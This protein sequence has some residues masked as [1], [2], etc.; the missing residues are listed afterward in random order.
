MSGQSLKSGVRWVVFG[1][2]AGVMWLCAG[3]ARGA[4]PAVGVVVEAAT[5][6]ALNE[7]A[8]LSKEVK[9]A[10]EAV[11]KANDDPDTDKD[12]ISW[13][14]YYTLGPEFQIN[15]SIDLKNEEAASYAKIDYRVPLRGTWDSWLLGEREGKFLN[16]TYYAKT[17]EPPPGHHN[18]QFAF[19]DWAIAMDGHVLFGPKVEVG[20]DPQADPKNTTSKTARISTSNSLPRAVGSLGLQTTLK[21]TPDGSGKNA[22]VSVGYWDVGMANA[23]VRVGLWDDATPGAEP[24]GTTEM[25]GEYVKL[26]DVRFVKAGDS[27][28][29]PLYDAEGNRYT[30][31][32]VY[33]TAAAKLLRFDVG[34]TE[35]TWGVNYAMANVT[36]SSADLIAIGNFNLR[37]ISSTWET[38]RT[39]YCPNW[40]YWLPRIEGGGATYE[41]AWAEMEAE[42]EAEGITLRD[43][44]FRSISESYQVSETPGIPE[45]VA[46][47]TLACAVWGCARRRA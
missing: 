20:V 47:L 23:G 11:G 22:I 43:G 12:T 45:P 15:L 29:A 2:L 41:Q 32:Q 6:V 38:D 44:L 30:N 19:I 27:V 8:Q 37:S 40:N 34:A 26:Y 35:G 25:P 9:F 18:P 5:G 7:L 3:G 1:S 39:F 42:V 14:G 31:E 4:G 46:L 28:L 16:K 10:G 13:L 36:E 33:Q 21:A 17:S 24:A